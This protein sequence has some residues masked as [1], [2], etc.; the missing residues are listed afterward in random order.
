M[1][2][3]SLFAAALSLGLAATP[4]AE[5]LAWEDEL[6]S[7][8][9]RWEH[10]TTAMDEARRVDALEALAEEAED[11]ADAHPEASTVLVWQGIVLA[12]LAREAGGLDALGAAKE[13]RRVLE[14]ALELDP[15]GHHGSAYVTLGALYDRA[16]G[17]PVAFGDDDTAERMFREALEIRPEGIDVHYYYAAY[18]EEEGRED[19]A[20][21]HARRAANGQ[22]REGREA[23]DEALREKAWAM[24][25]RLEG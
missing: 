25:D 1:I 3:R 15:R 8:R 13:A 14:R 4:L 19:E 2:R 6:F 21:V 18:L 20:L 17:W 5:A 9:S 24:V 10:T 16:P 12:S 22:A 23:S 11:L 7:L